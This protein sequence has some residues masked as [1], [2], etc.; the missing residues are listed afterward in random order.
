[1][2]DNEQSGKR[3]EVM[4][5][6]LYTWIHSKKMMRSSWLFYML[7]ILTPSVLI[8]DAFFLLMLFC[9]YVPNHILHLSY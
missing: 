4:K 2:R 8:L 6:K 9:F 1:M 5:L 3:K 7:K